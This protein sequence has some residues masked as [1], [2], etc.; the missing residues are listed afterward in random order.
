MWREYGA[1]GWDLRGSGAPG[2]GVL[3][4][5]L[6]ALWKCECCPAAEDESTGV[7]RVTLPG[8]RIPPSSLR[9]LGRFPEWGHMQRGG[10]SISSLAVTW[11]PV[12]LET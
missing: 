10:W 3:A 5:A 9:Q 6:V 4:A 1:R 11:V 7:V 12:W 8:G 2:A